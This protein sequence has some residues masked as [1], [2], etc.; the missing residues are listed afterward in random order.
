MLEIKNLIFLKWK[1]ISNKIKILEIILQIAAKKKAKHIYKR[2]L[3]KRIQSINK[4]SN[5]FSSFNRDILLNT[6]ITNIILY[7]VYKIK[8]INIQF[9]C[10]INICELVNFWNN[11]LKVFNIY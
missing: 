7:Y 3:A 10:I 6:I 1:L 4:I 9:A 8:V 5:Y 2:L 11:M